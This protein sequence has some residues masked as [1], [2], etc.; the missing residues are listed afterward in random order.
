MPIIH[1]NASALKINFS[2][3]LRL[4]LEKQNAI[5]NIAKIDSR[6]ILEIRRK[7]KKD[8][9]LKK[10]LVEINKSLN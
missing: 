3:I 7:S 9:A 8:P 2:F 10:L 4:C 5:N 1:C 6:M